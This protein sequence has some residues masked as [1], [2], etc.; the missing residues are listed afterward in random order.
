MRQLD[1]RI[2]EYLDRYGVGFPSE[3]ANHPGV[4]ASA[5]A[6]RERA[7]ILAGM[8]LLEISNHGTLLEITGEGRMYLRGDLRADL[9]QP[10]VDRSGA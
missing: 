1:E 4:S 5:A 9:R 6:V 2:L 3:L 8:D 10:R 7:E